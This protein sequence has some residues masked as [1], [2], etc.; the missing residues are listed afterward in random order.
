L[1]SVGRRDSTLFLNKTNPLNYLDP[2][3]PKPPPFLTDNEGTLIW[4]EAGKS[5]DSVNVMAYDGGS[6]AGPLVFNFQQILMNFQAYGPKASQV[7]MGFEPGEQNGGGV[8]E[9]YT[10]DVAVG[11]FIKEKGFGGAMLWPINPDPEFI[12]ATKWCPQVASALEK[13]ISPTWPFGK[14]PT[15][16][17]CN[18]Q[19]GW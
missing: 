19:T 4:P 10:K 2:S 16:S 12:N 17:K 7:N 8:W 14:A 5:F 15:Y 11:K 18:P 9:G 6:S 13:I 1:R 3:S